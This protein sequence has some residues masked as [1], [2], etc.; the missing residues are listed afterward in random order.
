MM[1]KSILSAAFSAAL[2]GL[3]LLFSSAAPAQQSVSLSSVANIYGIGTLGVAVTV[4]NLD[5]SGSGAYATNLLG[6]SL[7]FG[8]A[9]LNFLAPGA[10]SA[11]IK[12]VV[13]LPAGK[14]TAL[15]LLGGGTGT[16][17]LNQPFVVTYTDGTTKTFTQNLSNYG[18]TPQNYPNETVVVTMPYK[19]ST[20]GVQ[21]NGSYH[22]LGYSFALDSTKT[23][24]SFTLPNTSN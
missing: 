13:P 15:K 3:A 10:K 19:I 14:F 4:P 18:G 20:T 11:V 6:T 24:K 5:G 17:Q 9:S 12:A 1:S 21:H 22:V 23:V 16:N 8:G 7:S 2:L